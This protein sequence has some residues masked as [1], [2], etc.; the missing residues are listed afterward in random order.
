M[1][2][3]I[4]NMV[5]HWLSK[6]GFCLNFILVHS[7]VLAKYKF[8]H[9]IVISWLTNLETM[10]KIRNDALSPQSHSLQ[11]EEWKGKVTWARPI[12]EPVMGAVG[13]NQLR[14]V[15]LC[16]SSKGPLCFRSLFSSRCIFIFCQ[17]YFVCVSKSLCARLSNVLGC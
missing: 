12:H 2:F 3:W 7:K 14:S 15:I 10:I 6:L 9:R 11:E 5:L 1:P 16:I 17:L 8:D 4:P 13:L